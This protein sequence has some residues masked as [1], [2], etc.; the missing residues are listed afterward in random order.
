VDVCKLLISLGVNVNAQGGE[1]GYVLKFLLLPCCLL[2]FLKKCPS[3][4]SG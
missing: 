3:S 1:A 2:I 4:G